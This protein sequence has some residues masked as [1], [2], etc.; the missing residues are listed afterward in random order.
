M[1]VTEIEKTPTP[2]DLLGRQ[3]I[4]DRIMK[5]LSVISEN[6]SSCTFAL[7]GAWGTGKTFV[8]NMLMNQLWEYH[9]DEYIVFHY[10]CWQYD[11]YE[12]P[13]IAIVAAMLDSV[14]EESHLLPEHLR[15]KAKVAFKL[16][17]PVLQ[18]IATDFVRNK[19]GVDLT[20]VVSNVK[21]Y[22]DALDSEAQKKA[23][24]RSFDE[25]YSFKKAI[26][27]AQDE[28]RKITNE[29]TLVVVVDELDRCLPNYAIKV[30]ERL[31]HLFTNLTNSVIILGV[32]KGQLNTT[33]S[34]IFGADTNVSKYLEKFVN[35]ELSLDVGK[36]ACGFF[37]K[38][39]EYAALFD[40]SIIQTSFP[41]EEYISQLFSGIDIRTQERLMKKILTVHSII[42]PNETKDYSFMCFELLYL[43]AFHQGYILQKETKSLPITRGKLIPTNL[44][45]YELYSFSVSNALIPNNMLHVFLSFENK[46]NSKLLDCYFNPQ[47]GRNELTGDCVIQE[48]LYYYSRALYLAHDDF[49]DFITSDKDTKNTFR[50]TLLRNI[51]A[52]ISIVNILNTMN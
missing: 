9:S 40:R 42:C 14:D 41:Y 43:I 24:S 47:T 34:Q 15:D 17:K 46:E 32:D 16:A 11:Y 4:V 30:L 6:K 48:L 27:Q 22:K 37:D 3:E 49:N 52:L 10:N 25:F 12:E 18:K 39:A 26:Q 50:E 29:R 7:N 38:Y 8:L 28:I 51:Y 36:I 20:D 1:A 21:D 13:L 19:I 5:I 35:F 23:D 45:N 33:I 31:H 44:T 2:V